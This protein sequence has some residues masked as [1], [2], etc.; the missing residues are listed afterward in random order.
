M[1]VEALIIAIALYSGLNA[2]SNALHNVAIGIEVGSK[3]IADA[4]LD[5]E[6]E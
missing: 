5:E 2:I 1:V 3:S 6:F 4:I